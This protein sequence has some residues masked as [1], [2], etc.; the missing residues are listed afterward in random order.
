MKIRNPLPIMPWTARTRDLSLSGN[1]VPK[2]AIAAPK[3]VRINTQS[4]I[5]PS[6]LA[7][8]PVNL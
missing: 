8:T 4:S 5:E 6:W 2:M 1:P 3:I 7:H